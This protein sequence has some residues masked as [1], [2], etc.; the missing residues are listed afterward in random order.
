MDPKDGTERLRLTPQEMVT[1]STLNG[2][3][4]YLKADEGDKDKWDFLNFADAW[5]P[6]EMVLPAERS[7]ADAKDD[8]FFTHVRTKPPMW[9]YGL[10][11]FISVEAFS[12]GGVFW[13]PSWRP[14]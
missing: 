2:R 3:K 4:G 11:M 6:S 8:V 10:C 14:P 1:G 9:C 7:A 12:R 5:Q 13:M